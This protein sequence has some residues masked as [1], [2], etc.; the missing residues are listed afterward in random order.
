MYDI[1][2]L[3]NNGVWCVGGL[4]SHD[5]LLRLVDFINNLMNIKIEYY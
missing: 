3:Q 1:R 2:L 5:R 4:K